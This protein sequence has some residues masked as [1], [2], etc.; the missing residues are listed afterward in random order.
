[1]ESLIQLP[2]NE[3][4]FEFSLKGETSLQLFN[5][6]FKCVCVPNL[7]QRSEA[8]VLERQLNRD[9][10]TLDAETLAYHRMIAQLT[11]RLLAAPDWWI[12]SNNGQNLLDLN[13]VFEVWKLCMKAEKNWKDIVWKDEKKPEE[14]KE[15][16]NTSEANSEKE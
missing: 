9:L 16:D 7:R 13:V 14:K 4:V 3:E 11:S 5:G 15:L 10:A 8:A 6:K 1:M 12:S 2:V